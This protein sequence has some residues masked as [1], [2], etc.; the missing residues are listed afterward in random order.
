MSDSFLTQDLL[1]NQLAKIVKLVEVIPT[2]TA[3]M[4]DD[5]LRL[6]EMALADKREKVFDKWL[7]ERIKGMYVYIDPEFRG[8]AFENKNWVQ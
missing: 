3:S 8:G 7:S 5:Y 1:M 4:S 2:H 6:E